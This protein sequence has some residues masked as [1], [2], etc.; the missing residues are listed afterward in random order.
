MA[1]GSPAPTSRANVGPDRTAPGR[2]PNTSSA[3]SCGNSPLLISKPLL[4]QAM[5]AW[6]SSRGWMRRS[7]GRKACEGTATS[8]SRTPASAADR[9]A[10][11]SRLGGNSASGR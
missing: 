4:A 6:S 9:S 8:T 2:G 3:T 5:R 11:G 1:V 7:V 10:T